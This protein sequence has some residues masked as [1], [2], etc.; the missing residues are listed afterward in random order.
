MHKNKFWLFDA[1][2]DVFERHNF[3][4]HN[5]NLAKNKAPIAQPIREFIQKSFGMSLSKNYIHDYHV[6]LSRLHRGNVGA[7]FLNVGDFDLLQSS[8]MLNG[9]HKLST[10]HPNKISLCNEYNEILTAIKTNKIAIVLAVEGP[11]IF[12]EQIDLLCNWHRLGVKVISASHGEGTEGLTHDAKLIYKHI[13]K[14]IQQSALQI[15]TSSECYMS[16]TARKQLYKKERGLSP[17]GKL[18]IKEMERLNIICDLAHAS[19]ATFW[20]VLEKSAVKVCATH[21][22]C[23]ALC[24]HT[25]NLTDDMMKALAARQGVMGLCFYGNFINAKKPSLSA[26]VEHVL[27]ALAIMGPDYVG[28]G[29]DYD[30]VEPGSFMAIPNPAHMNDLWEALDKAGVNQKTMQKIA[31]GNFL[32]LLN[33]AI[34]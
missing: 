22:N 7:L 17:F 34:S 9:A 27:H 18:A 20:E 3:F 12:N 4:G 26:F 29:T 28:I 19:D 14:Q 23:A 13:Q 16:L 8:K 32:E 2:C 24:H 31:H 6:T 33:R 1:H 30:G 11:T 15:T 25:R 5:L 10:N 21:S